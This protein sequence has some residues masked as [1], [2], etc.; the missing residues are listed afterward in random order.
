MEVDNYYELERLMP[1]H[2]DVQKL[3]SA[4]KADTYPRVSASSFGH[5]LIL[6]RLLYYFKN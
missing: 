1:W 5:V 6:D 2:Q 4:M 3:C